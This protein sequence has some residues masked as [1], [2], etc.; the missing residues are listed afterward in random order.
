MYI[1]TFEK[2]KGNLNL[3][4]LL[5][6]IN[7][8]YPVPTRIKGFFAS[9]DSIIAP[10]LKS[11]LGPLGPSGVIATQNPFFKNFLK[12]K[13]PI[14]PFLL[15]EPLARLNL[16]LLKIFAINS[17]SLCRETR[18]AIPLFLWLKI[19][20][21]ICECQKQKIQLFFPFLML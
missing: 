9:L 2:G 7:L 16:K 21:K 19:N 11:H 4:Q 3:S 17:P 13:K 14:S 10:S 12:D 18:T 1:A 6:S 8:E 20:G 15:K 5:N